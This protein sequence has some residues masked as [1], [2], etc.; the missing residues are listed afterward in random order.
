M[1]AGE[2]PVVEKVT[3]AGKEKLRI[4]VRDHVLQRPVEISVD[5]LNLA[6]AIIQGLDELARFFKGSSKPGRVFSLRPT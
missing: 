4:R 6:T 2:K 1:N 5:Y 3:V